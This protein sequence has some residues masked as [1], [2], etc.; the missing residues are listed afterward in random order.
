[1][2][3]KDI[4]KYKKSPIPKLVKLAQYHFNLFIRNRDIDKPCISCGGS[5][6]SQAGHYYS[7][8]HYPWLRF[9]PDNCHRQC[10]R[11]NMYLS[12]NLIMYRHGLVSRYGE[13]M[14]KRLDAMAL[15][16]RKGF[17]YDRFSIIDTILKYK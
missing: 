15:V 6:A 4:E 10:A 16:N 2:E 5:N 3:V 12:G 13:D 14:V 17:K 8:G 9:H 11:C 7:A 1:M